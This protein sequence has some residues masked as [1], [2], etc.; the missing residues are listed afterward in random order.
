[1]HAKWSSY[2]A[3]TPYILFCSE[4]KETHISPLIRIRW[5]YLRLAS[6]LLLLS[7]SLK[8]YGSITLRYSLHRKKVKKHIDEKLWKPSK[9]KIHWATGWFRTSRTLR[10]I[11]AHFASQSIPRVGPEIF[12]AFIFLRGTGLFSPFYVSKHIPSHVT[13]YWFPMWR[14]LRPSPW[15]DWVLSTQFMR[16]SPLYFLSTLMFHRYANR[17]LS[18]RLQLCGPPFESFD[19]EEVFPSIFLHN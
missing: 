15:R 10:G 16:T 1:M 4:S 13:A 18:T 3:R 11:V 12:R 5:P 14:L 6:I 2:S 9:C 19:D 17:W 7:W 8:C